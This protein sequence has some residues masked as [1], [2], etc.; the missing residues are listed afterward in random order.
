MDRL[1][2][3][4][5]GDEPDLNSADQRQKNID[6]YERVRERFPRTILY[7]NNWGMQIQ[8][9]AYQDFIARASPT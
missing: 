7:T 4:S 9:A 3:V 6:W 1:I 5:L 8:D 2:S